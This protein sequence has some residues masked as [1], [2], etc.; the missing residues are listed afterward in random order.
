MKFQLST[1]EL[2]EAAIKD[3]PNFGLSAK[4]LEEDGQNFVEFESKAYCDTPTPPANPTWDDYYA[5]SKSVY[6]EMQYQLKWIRE[7]YQYLSKA[8]YNH[9]RGHIPAILDVGKLQAAINTLG[10]GDSYEVK[11]AEVYVTY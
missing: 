4:L 11:R 5:L 1:L 10:I 6:S 7:D 3:A 9:Q 2:S 8:F